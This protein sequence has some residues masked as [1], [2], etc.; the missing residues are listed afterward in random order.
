MALADSTVERDAGLD[1]LGEIALYAA[2][3][4]RRGGRELPSSN[5][6]GENSQLPTPQRQGGWEFSLASLMH[7]MDAHDWTISH[8]PYDLRERL[9]NFA[10]AIT[11]VAQFL[12]T[13][14]PIAITLFAQVLRSGTSAG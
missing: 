13:R 10:C 2:G 9:F 5:S 4:G 12:L 11:R 6:Q 8:K 3:V 7:V 14:G 1:G